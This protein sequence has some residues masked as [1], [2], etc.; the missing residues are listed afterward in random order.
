M[1]A[2]HITKLYWERI[3]LKLFVP[4]AK[5]DTA[6]I[7]HSGR[8]SF[9][10]PAEPQGDGMLL[11]LNMMNMGDEEPVPTGCWYIQAV[12]RGKLGVADGVTEEFESLS[13]VYPYA[14]YRYAY[15]V[16]FHVRERDETFFIEIGRA[17]V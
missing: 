14:K 10:V 8:R 2:L 11:T 5:E 15:T 4:G 3:H 17:H 13:R 7:M 9:P 16:S 12:G 1:H 6:F